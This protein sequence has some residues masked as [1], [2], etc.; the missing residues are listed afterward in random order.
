MKL[1]YKA[2]ELRDKTAGELKEILLS[3]NKELYNI[4][5]QLANKALEDT[6]KKRKVRCSIARVK[7]FLKNMINK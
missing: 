5:L 1:L 2:S 6:S 3:L 4:R 7:T